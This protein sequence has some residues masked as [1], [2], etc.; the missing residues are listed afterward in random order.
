MPMNSA[1]AGKRGKRFAQVADARW[2]MSYAAGLGQSASRYLDT[3]KGIVAHPLFPVCLEWPVIL[4]VP[5]IEHAGGM[6]AAE[7]GRGVHALHDLHIHRP[8][9]AGDALFT[10][11]SL[12]GVEQRKPGAFQS[13][14][15]DTV[16][17]EGLP[18]ATTWQG[19]LLRGVQVTGGDRQVESWPDAPVLP[20]TPRGGFVAEVPIAAEAAHTYTECARIFNPIHTD[21]AVALAAGLPDIILHGTATLAHAVN[22]VVEQVLQGESERVNR[23]CGR[24]AAMVPMPNTL[25]MHVQHVAPDGVFLHVKNA[26]GEIVI[27][28][29]YVGF[30]A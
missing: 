11:L 9:M 10:T 12:I 28:D 18:V 6:D 30:T 8:I 15:M 21:R 1:C 27:R 17:A 24:F 23:I 3:T 13:M 7:R 25:Q 14:R 5:N 2:L 29:C 19:S 26:V 22:V 20:A 16:D 4:D